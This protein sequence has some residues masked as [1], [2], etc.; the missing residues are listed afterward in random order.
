MNAADAMTADNVILTESAARRINEIGGGAKVLRVAVNGGGCSGFSYG[1]ELED[2]PAG[3]DIVLERNGARVVID[4]V[5]LDFLKGSK[6]DFKDEL[7]G[8]TF[9][10]ENP[11][12]RS[13]CG[14]GVSFSV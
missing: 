9:R 8:A 6:I 11:N 7:I 2:A 14:C 12:A 10:I 1:F 5:S 3:D 13:S 4:P